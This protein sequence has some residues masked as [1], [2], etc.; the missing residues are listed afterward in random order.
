MLVSRSLWL[1]R[2]G[3]GWKTRCAVWSSVAG[4]SM[5]ALAI[6]G[7]REM[8]GFA[9]PLG[10]LAFTANLV[11]PLTIRCRVCGL[12]LE[13][14]VAARNLARDRRLQWMESR[15]ACP[16]CHDDGSARDEAR[17]AWRMSGVPPEEPYWSATRL[18]LAI[19]AACAFIGGALWFGSRYRVR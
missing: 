8:A 2:A 15:D 13:T 18:I 3:Q 7:P 1:T 4:F 14:C 16:V 9:I 17:A 6:V 12:Q 11:L 5:M 19:A 10:F